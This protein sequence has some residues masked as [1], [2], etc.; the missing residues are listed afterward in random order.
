MVLLIAGAA[1]LAYG[2]VFRR[3]PEE[4]VRRQVAALADAVGIDQG[5]RDPRARPLRILRSFR[6]LL[7][8]KVHVEVTDLVEDVHARDEL[9]GMAVSAAQTFRS[10]DVELTKV[11]VEVDASGRTA[12]AT[13]VAIVTGTDHDGRRVRDVRPVTMRF[14][15]QDGEWRF[16]SF[17]AESSPAPEP[18]EAP[19]GLASAAAH[20]F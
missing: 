10:L 12:L 19:E 16:A 11:Q 3:T 5:E 20:S 9:A 14:E 8:P 13:A 7:A 4:R 18:P 15:D 2:L 1:V 6:R 17:T